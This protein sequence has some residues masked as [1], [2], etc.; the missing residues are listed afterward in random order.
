MV[1]DSTRAQPPLAFIPPVFNPL[2]LKV[3]QVILPFWLRSQTPLVE[4][5]AE[6]LFVLA[7][8]FQKFQQKKVR[9]LLAFRHPS[10]NDP[11]CMGYLLWKLLPKFIKQ[12][13]IQ[14]QLPIHAHFMYESRDSSLGRK[15]GEVALFPFRRNVNSTGKIG[16]SWTAIGAKNYWLMRLSQ[17]PPLLRGQLMAITKLLVL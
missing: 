3:C 9:F 7:E 4:I 11:Y 15:Y 6:N 1:S 10:I 14:L 17:S 8:Y 2:V 12:E 5:E 16:Y 13:N